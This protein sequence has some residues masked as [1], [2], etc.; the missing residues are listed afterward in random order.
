M[1]GRCEI[2][3][4][5]RLFGGRSNDQARR[6]NLTFSTE[7][8]AVAANQERQSKLFDM[9]APN[10]QA[11]GKMLGE[12]G[13]YYGQM[14]KDPME[15]LAPELQQEQ[16]AY[17]NISGSNQFQARGG[18]QISRQAGLDT[19]HLQ[20]IAGIIQQGRARGAAGVGAVGSTVGQIAASQVS[21]STNIGGLMSQL[22]N[23]FSGQNQQLY[24]NQQQAMSSAGAGIG[25]LLALFA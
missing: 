19:Q 12:V 22:L 11:A 4:I 16:S 9:A 5:K 2:S 1:K 8:T 18:G 14:M 21:G 3:F 23:Q 20:N 15:A 6:D 24:Q 25:Q 17:K 13:D 7:Q 10:Y